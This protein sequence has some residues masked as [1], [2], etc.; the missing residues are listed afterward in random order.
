MES[1]SFLIKDGILNFTKLICAK[2]YIV[3]RSADLFNMILRKLIILVLLISI[4]NCEK[5]TE[6]QG[7][8]DKSG[9]KF[10]FTSY[11]IR[12][13]LDLGEKF[14]NEK[15]KT[16]KLPAVRLELDAGPGKGQAVVRKLRIS[17][18]RWGATDGSITVKGIWS[19]WYKFLVKVSVDGYFIAT[20]QNLSLSTI[21][22]VTK[23]DDGRPQIRVPSCRAQVGAIRLKITGGTVPKIVNF[24]RSALEEAIEGLIKKQVCEQVQNGL[25][26]R[27]NAKIHSLPSKIKLRDGPFLLDYTLTKDPLV[28][29]DFFEAAIN[30]AITFEGERSLVPAPVIPE[31]RE[32]DRMLY[33]W[34]SDFIPQ[35]FFTSLH[36][37]NLTRFEID[38]EKMP[39]AARYLRTKCPGSTCVGTFKE[40]IADEYPYKWVALE[41][42]T[43]EPPSLVFEQDKSLF[44]VQLKADMYIE[45][46]S[47]PENLIMTFLIEINATILPFF[48]SNNLTCNVTVDHLDLQ[49]NYTTVG[50]ISPLEIYFVVEYGRPA[51]QDMINQRLAPGLR[52]PT[53]ENIE[54]LHPRVV[55]L[56]RAWKIETDFEYVPPA[57]PS[58]L[59]ES[60]QL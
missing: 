44:A 34:L 47:K 33:I 52:I 43:I 39:K 28:T 14:V 5:A 40:E 25:V 49:V 2:A 24:F 31:T 56:D 42:S 54:L 36:D 10:R 4:H 38:R 27:A 32:S 46:A 60:N 18:Y 50:E 41:I 12:Y 26:E 35:S 58:E 17:D 48:K 51:L 29:D 23:S 13:A 53:Y 45:P 22:D 30:G 16:A 20:V 7:E 57:P 1:K 37:H 9:L 55:Q 11:G 21:L 15:L 59:E 8:E 3:E 19:A 6:Y